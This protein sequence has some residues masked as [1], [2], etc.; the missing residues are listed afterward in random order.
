MNVK[1][2]IATALILT[3]FP[4]FGEQSGVTDQ[5]DWEDLFGVS[6]GSS[7]PEGSSND[8]GSLAFY[9]IDPPADPDAGV[10]VDGGILTVIGGALYYGARQLRNKGQKD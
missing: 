9:G 7:D 3:S 4:L 6:N 2:F 8:G 1:N 10:P 5:Q